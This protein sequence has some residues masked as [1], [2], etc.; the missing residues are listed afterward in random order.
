M[1]KASVQRTK[2]SKKKSGT[3]S[4]TSSTPHSVPRPARRA[5]GGG[6]LKGRCKERRPLS[7]NR[8][9]HVVLSSSE[10]KGQLAFTTPANRTIVAEI[11]DERGSQFGII[12]ELIEARM[13][14][15]HF[16]LSF[17]DRTKFQGFLRTVTA[18]IAR[19]ITGARKG[20]PFGRKFWNHIAF[21]RTL[22]VSESAAN[23]AV[24]SY[25]NA[26]A[27]AKKSGRN[28]EDLLNKI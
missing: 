3:T 5:H 26:V 28:L 12:V 13:T 15:L 24:D 21:T 4:P 7:P 25:E 16:I 23:G 27:I 19:R 18:L 8:L 9:T 10:A 1:K 14:H 20:H 22:E 11:L 2:S 17:K 6:S